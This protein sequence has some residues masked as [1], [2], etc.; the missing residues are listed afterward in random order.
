ARWSRF[1]LWKAMVRCCI[2]QPR[3][4]VPSGQATIA[5]LPTTY[6]I[7]GVKRSCRAVGECD[8]RTS[9]RRRWNRIAVK[10][11]PLVE[12]DRPREPIGTKRRGR[13][14][15][16]RAGSRL[17]GDLIRLSRYSVCGL[18]EASRSTNHRA[19]LTRPSTGQSA[20]GIYAE[21]RSVGQRNRRA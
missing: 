12:E 3:A 15:S 13:C 4:T 2:A 18:T 7:K 21:R 19:A 5:C 9:H 14:V 11:L 20:R 10:G 6:E 16:A 8:G 17:E 1:Y